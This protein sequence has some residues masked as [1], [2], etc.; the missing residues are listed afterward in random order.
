MQGGVIYKEGV[1]STLKTML[2]REGLRGYFKGNG[3]NV[4]KVIPY[5]AIRFFFV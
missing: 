4:M 2:E 5:N 3:T 1:V